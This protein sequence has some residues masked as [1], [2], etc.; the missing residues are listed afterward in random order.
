MIE[1]HAE[2]ILPCWEDLDSHTAWSERKIRE[3]LEQVGDGTRKDLLRVLKELRHFLG[4]AELRASDQRL[5]LFCGLLGDSC[6]IQHATLIAEIRG[7]QTTIRNELS[8]RKFTFIPTGKA[9][10]C[11]GNCLFGETVNDAFPSARAEIMDAGNCIAAELDTAA[12]FHLMRVAEIG[13][14]GLAKKLQVAKVRKGDPIESGTWADIIQALENKVK[15]SF[16]KTKEGQ[17]ESDF[18]K[19]VFIEYR[20]FKDF[21]RNKVM[22]A[23]ADYD[24]HAAL[25]AFHHVRAFMQRLATRVSEVS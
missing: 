25:S 12:V 21:W 3:T 8:E 9:R 23:R 10:F 24:E 22:H 7:L 6:G 11:E 16:P 13:L 2:E 15:G 1:F 18:Y 4:S 17:E 5:V 20:A 19:E 14:R